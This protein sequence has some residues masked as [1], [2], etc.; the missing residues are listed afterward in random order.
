MSGIGGRKKG[1]CCNDI[2]DQLVFWFLIYDHIKLWKIQTKIPFYI[3]S[4]GYFSSLNTWQGVLCIFHGVNTFGIKV[5]EKS[6]FPKNNSKFLK[7]FH[8]SCGG[9]NN[10]LPALNSRDKIRKEE[11]SWGMTDSPS[12][13][14]LRFWHT[15]KSGAEREE[16]AMTIANNIRDFCP[17]NLDFLQL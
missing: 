4:N 10:Q 17:V 3:V 1:G 16:R 8:T 12:N 13:H 7:L 6:G 9:L 11:E 5:A 15:F 2:Y 14:P